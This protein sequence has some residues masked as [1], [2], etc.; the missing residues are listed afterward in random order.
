MF[1]ES[2]N[3]GQSVYI[4]GNLQPMNKRVEVQVTVPV[5]YSGIHTYHRRPICHTLA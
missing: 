1:A 3:E 4:A 5:L 2:T